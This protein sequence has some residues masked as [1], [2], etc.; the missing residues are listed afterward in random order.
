M[1]Y[2]LQADIQTIVPQSISLVTSFFLSPFLVSRTCL[3]MSLHITI[4][5]VRRRGSVDRFSTPMPPPP[6][7]SVTFKTQP[8][9]FLAWWSMQPTRNVFR[10]DR[11]SS[12]RRLEEKERRLQGEGERRKRAEMAWSGRGEGGGLWGRRYE[13]AGHVRYRFGRVA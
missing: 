6:L 5:I 2:R 8:C 12:Y 1:T 3:P 7:R 11:A 13:T 9:N 10:A 4:R